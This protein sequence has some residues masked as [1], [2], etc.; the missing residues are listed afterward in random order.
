[1]GQTCAGCMLLVPI[2]ERTRCV[3]PV[4]RHGMGHARWLE[5]STPCATCDRKIMQHPLPGFG[6]GSSD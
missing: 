6:G 1:M 3:A 5:P 4:P 2:G